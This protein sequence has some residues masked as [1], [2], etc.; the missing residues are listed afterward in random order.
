[1]MRRLRVHALRSLPSIRPGSLSPSGL[2]ELLPALFRTAPGLVVPSLII[3]IN[4]VFAVLIAGY[5]NP[6][7]SVVDNQIL[8]C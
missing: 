4:R 8:T 2:Y 3:K 7:R 5:F 1:M 6:V